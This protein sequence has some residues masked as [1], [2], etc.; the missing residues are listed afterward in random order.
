MQKGRDKV[1]NFAMELLDV[2][3]LS[4]KLDTALKKPKCAAKF[5][6]AS[7]FVLKNVEDGICRHN[8]APEKKTLIERP[9]LVATKEALVKIKEG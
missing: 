4:K 8:Y 6:V 9:K 5:I 2:H 3:T 7:C 1:I